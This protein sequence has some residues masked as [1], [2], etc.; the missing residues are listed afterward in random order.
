MQGG[1]RLPG[2]SRSINKTAKKSICKRIRETGMRNR[3]DLSLEEI[4]KWLNP[5]LDGW[6][7]YYGKF[8]KSELNPVMR[9]I[10][11]TLI[12]WS[13]RKYKKFRYSRAKA[14]QFMINTFD[15]RPYLF[16]HWRRGVSGSFV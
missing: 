10:N 9:Q 4:A 2:H 3:S 12:K 5:M 11:F 13:T 7:N 6:I 14:C 1:G 8:S 15:S 16:A